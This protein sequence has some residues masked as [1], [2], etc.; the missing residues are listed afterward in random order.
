MEPGTV[1]LDEYKR[2]HQLVECL[3]RGGQGEVWSTMSGRHVVKI[4]H[5]RAGAEDVRRQF[6]R[7][8][9]ALD[10]LRRSLD[11]HPQ[12]PDVRGMADGLAPQVDGRDI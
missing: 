5:D 9:R 1:V 4:R 11:L 8:K 3:G 7:I 2:R 6:L 10:A 12:Q